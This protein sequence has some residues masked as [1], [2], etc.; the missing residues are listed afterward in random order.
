MEI[1]SG[2]C[3]K[4][5]FPKFEKQFNHLYTK[6][7]LSHALDHQNKTRFHQSEASSGCFKY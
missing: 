2:I 4:E 5:N 6:Q 7:N 1:N 3:G